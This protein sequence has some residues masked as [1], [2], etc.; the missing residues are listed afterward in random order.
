MTAQLSIAGSVLAGAALAAVFTIVGW[1]VY[2]GWLN[3]L[4]D[5]ERRRLLD[6]A[7]RGVDEGPWTPRQRLGML[8]L[9]LVGG[10]AALVVASLLR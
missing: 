1:F 4:S 8:V 9:V 7:V 3:R 6:R 5:H 2:R 10:I